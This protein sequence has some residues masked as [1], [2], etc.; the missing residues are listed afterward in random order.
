MTHTAGWRQGALLLGPVL[1]DIQR[2]LAATP[3]VAVLVPIMMALPALMIALVAPFA[4]IMTDRLGRRGPLL[5]ALALYGVVGMLPMW[6]GSLQGII[7][8]RALLGVTEAVIMTSAT[9]LI[10]DYFEGGTRAR[11]L[12]FQGAAASLAAMIFFGLGGALGELG[13][14]TPFLMYASSCFLLPLAYFLLRE[15]VGAALTAGG[16]RLPW[17][18]LGSACPLAVTGAALLVMPIQAGFVLNQLG[19]TAPAAG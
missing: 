7:V 2:E 9:T 10:G 15:P 3:N 19:I 13:W 6:L 12:A 11:W 17:R 14:R 8:S 1:P 4:G 18:G 16:P 5:A